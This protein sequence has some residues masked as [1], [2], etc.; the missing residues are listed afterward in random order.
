VV[1]APALTPP[2]REAL[3]Q[4][5]AVPADTPVVLFVGR[6]VEDKNVPCLLRA[7]HRL[8][9][10][11]VNLRALLAGDGPLLEDIRKQIN[12]AMLHNVVSLLGERR[13]VPQLMQLA[14]IVVSPSFREGL[15]NTIIE[16]MIAGTAVVASAVGGSV[17]LIRHRDNGWLFESDDDVALADGLQQLLSDHELRV[18]LGQRAQRDAEQ[19]FSVSLM[20]RK[21][22]RVYEEAAGND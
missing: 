18:T 21:F 6:L 2:Q 10:R 1:A 16:A 11:Q 12:A 8:V 15:S 20:T 17:E 7:L 9:Q 4:S 22:T 3:R 13:D 14:D 19:R 5:L